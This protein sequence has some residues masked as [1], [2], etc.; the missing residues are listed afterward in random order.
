[1]TLII[2]IESTWKLQSRAGSRLGADSQHEDL[3]RRQ[4]P[5]RR[6]P[7]LARDRRFADSPLE[8]GVRCE[9]VSKFL[10][11]IKKGVAGC[12]RTQIPC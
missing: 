5:Y 9:L 4:A 10:E 6:H 11:S 1:M 3:F 7:D 8:G 12:E 2:G